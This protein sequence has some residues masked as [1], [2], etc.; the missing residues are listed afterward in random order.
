MYF[1]NVFCHKNELFYVSNNKVWVI[2]LDSNDVD[3]HKSSCIIS[4]MINPRSLYIFELFNDRYLSFIAD[5]NSGSDVYLYAF[6]KKTIQQITYLNSVHTISGVFGDN[7]VFSSS[8]DSPLRF[9]QLF[10]LNLK[11]IVANF[12]DPDVEIVHSINFGP[13]RKIDFLSS[14]IGDM[15]FIEAVQANNAVLLER[16]G[17]GYRSW[18]G[19]RGGLVG[20]LLI[21][22]NVKQNN[23]KSAGNFKLLSNKEYFAHSLGNPQ[24]AK[25][26][27]N[28]VFFISENDGI[29]CIDYH[30]DKENAQNFDKYDV[31]QRNVFSCDLSGENV[32]QHTFHDDFSVS[33]Y[34]LQNGKIFYTCGGDI[35]SVNISFAKSNPVKMIIDHVDAI[36]LSNKKVN[37]EQYVHDFCVSDSGKEIGLIA[38]GQLF[39]LESWLTGCDRFGS[40]DVRYTQVRLVNDKIFT[41]F[42]NAE[43]YYIAIYDEDD[44][45]TPIVQFDHDF[46]NIFSVEISKNGAYAV[47]LNHRNEIILLKIQDI[48]NQNE[49][50]KH[51]AKSNDKNDK[52]DDIKCANLLKVGEFILIDKGIN[53]KIY[54]DWSANDEYIAYS[55]LRDNAIASSE[56]VIFDLKDFSKHTIVK[57]DF[58]NFAPKFCHSGNYLFFLSRN[59]L[60]PQYG[61]V[62]FSMHFHDTCKA[63]IV[64]LNKEMPSP[65]SL[66]D[67][68]SDVE[69]ESKIAVDFDGIQNRILPFPIEDAEF[70]DIFSF[71]DKVGFV[72]E[73]DEKFALE[74]FDMHTLKSEE[75]LSEMDAINVSSNGKWMIFASKGKL[76]LAKGGEKPETAESYKNNGMIDLN[77]VNLQIN[78]QKEFI[79]IFRE[80]VKL[81]KDFFWSKHVADCLNDI[82]LRYIYL[83]EKVT[84]RNE[85][86]DVISEF[87]GELTCSH[88]YVICDGDVTRYRN[89][90]AVLSA[91]L[92]F[93]EGISVNVEIHNPTDDND[94]KKVESDKSDDKKCDEVIAKESE[95]RAK[96]ENLVSICAN[97]IVP[98]DRS[99]FAYDATEDY[100]KENG[101]IYKKMNISGYKVLSILESD[102][103][104]VSPLLHADCN[105]KVGDYILSINGV[106]LNRKNSPEKILSNAKDVMNMRVYSDKKIRDVLLYPIKSNMPLLY[107][108]WVNTNKQYVHSKSNGCVGYIHIP[109]MSRDGFTEFYRS[110]LNERSKDAIIVDVRFNGGGN[111][112]TLLLEKLSQIKFGYDM[113]RWS[114]IVDY[115]LESRK[116]KLV[117]LC[118]EY[119]ASDG[120]MFTMAVQELKL[121]PVIGK[122]TWGGV[123]GIETRFHLI[124]N[125]LTSQPEFAFVLNSKKKVEN[126]GVNPD[127]F[128]DYMPEDYQNEIDPILNYGIEIA[129]KSNE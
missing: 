67:A 1:S 91:K 98:T 53:D 127:H 25:F 96:V 4:G 14:D 70:C 29:D 30:A 10:Y 71:K 116:G 35:F 39:L 114:G 20:E 109:D 83:A 12:D 86:N 81:Q 17:Y 50:Q 63:Y 129:M 92:A 48:A 36:L 24:S 6:A 126:F 103:N 101:K 19:Y 118:N 11:N 59:S 16:N 110:Y 58:I 8:H 9:P 54:F 104:I 107:R 100:I 22:H 56:I 42:T 55:L 64:M 15:N 51:N 117:F 87:H 60:K 77:R 38:R 18:K 2:S 40:T 94:D 121:G 52:K 123:V 74:V 106:M 49:E 44:F 93:E 28:R 113:T 97:V 69:C 26:Y 13:A 79:F 5:S 3:K 76:R 47:I 45:Y 33:S 72:L 73:N 115:P 128:V 80:V 108:S 75:V 21:K 61:S 102:L 122:R 82:A 57:N 85:L 37:P 23:A 43:R 65:F 119:T 111:I 68:L 84:N 120:D 41:V 112:S 105:L 88:A 66:G 62:H 90:G 124:D 27:D 34:S 89:T 125:G 95:L 32:V 99:N 31:Q 7:I 46:G 78:L